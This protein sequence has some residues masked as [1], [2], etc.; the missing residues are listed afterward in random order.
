M[1]D[2]DNPLDLRGDNRDTVIDVVS[3][4]GRRKSEKNRWEQ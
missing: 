1:D 2:A 4:G 3:S